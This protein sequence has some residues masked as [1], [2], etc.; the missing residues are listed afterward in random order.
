MIRL[1]ILAGAILIASFAAAHAGGGPSSRDEQIA[2]LNLTLTVA[3][4]CGIKVNDRRAENEF[5]RLYR[6]R[7]NSRTAADWRRAIQKRAG[8]D[9]AAG[10]EAMCHAGRAALKARGLNRK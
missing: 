6:W 9:E 3:Y 5:R 1:V 4:R 2:G 7:V 8:R 10:A